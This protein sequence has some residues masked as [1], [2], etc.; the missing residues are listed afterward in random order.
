MKNIFSI[1]LAALLIAACS[2]TPDLGACQPGQL[3]PCKVVDEGL[4]GG[5]SGGTE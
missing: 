2:F 3:G 1:L 4:G 5:D